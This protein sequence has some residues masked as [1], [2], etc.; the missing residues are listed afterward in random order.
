MPSS[1]VVP[2]C[3]GNYRNGPK[4]SIFTFPKDSELRKKWITAIKRDNFTPTEY[5][6]VSI[7]L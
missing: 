7:V 3:R 4:V 5:S 6:C 2:R 1:C